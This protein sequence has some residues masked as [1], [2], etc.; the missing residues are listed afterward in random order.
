M[1]VPILIAGAGPTGLA[2]AL[3]L[4]R[5]GV[6]FRIVDRNDGPSRESRALAV[7]ARTLELYDQAGF[8]ATAIEHGI[9]FEALNLWARGEKAAHARF[10]EIGR[11]LSP[12]PYVLILPQDFHER[13][14]VD[15]LA[16]RGV[17][18]ERNTRL[19][20]FSE[21][22]GRV[23][24]RLERT[25]GTAETT[26]CDWLAGCDGAHSV[27]RETLAPGFPGGTYE[28]L[29]YVADVEARGPVV[30]G[31]LNVAL[32]ESDLLAVFPL[33]D[34]GRVRLVGTIRDHAKGE[35]RSVGWDDVSR[36]ILERLRIEV[37][38][39]NWFSTYRVHHR[40]ASRFRIGRAF[41]L[42][43][44]AHI[45]SPVGGQGMNTGIGDAVNLAW[46]LAATV[47][48]PAAAGLLDTYETERIA[49]AR[50]LVATTD[51]A[52]TFASSDGALARFVRVHLVPRLVPAVL[53]YEA[54]R[55]YF[56]RT[57]SQIR[58]HYRDSPLS[59]G[60]AGDIRGGDRMPW[61]GANF[62]PLASL[63]WQ[64]QVH[65]SPSDAVSSACRAMGIALHAFPWSDRAQSAGLARDAPYLLRPDGYVGYADP[66]ASVAGLEAY[67][68]ERVRPH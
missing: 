65:G 4:Q 67:V 64:V 27:V 7:Q 31:E 62:A 61:T 11:G 59:A 26:E 5:L 38:A 53:G 30:N 60:R 46:K 21:T 9:R 66:S 20:S 36:G 34:E 13:L 18:V 48:G 25:D 24:A 32:D 47:K 41:L 40:V 52:F 33:R 8:A 15:H 51:R 10:G 42:G 56:F 29:F 57:V 68:R 28:H 35:T 3:W 50:R 17:H 54:G 58:V 12:F 19:A 2:L 14:L 39:V 37:G 55:R 16:E 44:A 1:A 6:P 22:G 45:H 49:F 63:D 23:V 43:D